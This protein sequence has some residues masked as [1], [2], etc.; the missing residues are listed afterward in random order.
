[1]FGAKTNENGSFSPS[2]FHKS[3]IF[4]FISTRRKDWKTSTEASM[5]KWSDTLTSSFPT[6]DTHTKSGVLLANNGAT[7]W[8]DQQV[9]VDQY[10]THEGLEIN[11]NLTVNQ[12]MGLNQWKMPQNV[13]KPDYYHFI[14]VRATKIA[15]FVVH[16]KL[17]LGAGRFF[18]PIAAPI[19]CPP[20]HHHTQSIAIRCFLVWDQKTSLID[21][22]ARTHTN[23]FESH[24]I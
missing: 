8:R 22:A 3:L 12:T 13:T 14:S 10:V 19:S 11:L 21:E 1:M 7:T 5:Q 6:F 23:W 2:I 4:S 17:Y 9:Y 16:R 24:Q 15:D 18:Y 20:H